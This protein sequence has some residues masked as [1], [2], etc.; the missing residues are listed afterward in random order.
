MKNKKIILS[1]VVILSLILLLIVTLAKED[2]QP[3][4][5]F[6]A[7]RIV[8]HAMG[9]IDGHA[10]TNA[11]EAFVAN[12]EKGTRI[13]ETDLL[14]T[15]DD[16]LVARH[17]WTGNMSKELGQQKVLSAKEQGS[18]LGYAEF[19]NSPILDIYSPLDFEKILDLLQHY[20]DAYIVTD[21]KEFDSGLVMKEFNRLTEAAKRR[22]PELLN[23]IVPQI[24]SRAMLEELKAVYSFPTVIYTLYQSQD[25]DEQ[26]ID[27]VRTTGVDITMPA[28]RATSSFVNKLQQA[29]ARVYVHTINAEE[30]IQKM[31]KLGVDGFYSD[32]IS[33]DDL[34]LIFK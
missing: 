8:A 15:S 5:G 20:P 9:G 32:F 25:T 19:M 29:G 4:T 18:A 31:D 17:E 13:F 27:F 21:T 33:E 3:A 7:S 16:K 12:Y 11:F 6:A 24:Y 14:F 10:Y 23:R 22:D 30:E 1:V 34:D 26:V 28:E 2:K